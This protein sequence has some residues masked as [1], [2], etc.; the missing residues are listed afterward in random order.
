MWICS[1]MI[2][3]KLIDRKQGKD[4]RYGYKLSVTP[5]MYNAAGKVVTTWKTFEVAS[6]STITKN[7]NLKMSCYA[8]GTYTLKLHC[9][10]SADD[11]KTH[12][13]TIST[14]IEHSKGSVA[15]KGLK[16]VTLTDGITYIQL[17]YYARGFKG[18]TAKMEIY[19]SKNQLV[20]CGAW[21]GMSSDDATPY[22]R[23]DGYPN[24]GKSTVRCKSGTY[25]VKFTVGGKSVTKN[26][27]LTMK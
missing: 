24:R 19:D 5:K 26:L 25:T 17:S 13:Y 15:Y 12:S 27:K 4:N 14:K 20:Y 11:G 23:W 3:T 18:K 1:R 2:I 10:I 8:S 16:Y 21:K 7:L 22:I 9:T 6:G